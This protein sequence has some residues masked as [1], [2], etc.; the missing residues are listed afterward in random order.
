MAG[1]FKNL[2]AS[3]IRLT[4]FRS[5]KKW[6]S[7]I[8]YDNYYTNVQAN[9]ESIGLLE[10]EVTRV[11]VSDASSSRILK[12]NQSDR[13]EILADEIVT[14]L[15][16]SQYGQD[17]ARSYVAS[18]GTNDLTM[19]DSDLQVAAGGTYSSTVVNHISD[20][21]YAVSSSSTSSYMF[22]AGEGGI[23]GKEFSTL[24]GNFIGSEFTP[25][26]IDDAVTGSFIAVNA[27][28]KLNN[29]KVVALV[30][31][32]SLGVFA[33]SFTGSYTDP[34]NAQ[35]SS[36][37]SPGSAY[38]FGFYGASVYGESIPIT[39][40]T[41][42]Y[43]GTQD[44]YFALFEDG[45]LYKVQ[46]NSTSTLVASGVAE[47]LQD[48]SNFTS[49]SINYQT[50]KIH[51]VYN[52]GQVGIDLI[53]T[54]TGYNEASYEKLID[55]RQ[56]V[57]RKPIVKATIQQN[58]TP[59]TIGIF[60]G[61]TSSLVEQVFFTVNPDTYEIGNPCHFGAT[62]GDLRIEVGNKADN[63]VDVFIGFSSLFSERFIEMSS[64][65]PV[66]QLYKADYNPIPS[67]PSYNPLNTLFDQGSPT[68]DRYEAVTWEGKFQRVVHKSLNHL[69]YESFYNN[70]K[71]VFGNGNINNQ[72][73]FLEDQAY[74]IDLPQ[75]K[76]GEAIQQS[77][78]II[79]ASYNISGS[80]NN[81][82]TIVDDLFGNLYVSGGLVSPVDAT[83]QASGSMSISP[84][85]EWPTKD[86]YKYNGKGAQSFTS[87]FNQGNWQ[88]QTVYENI[89]FTQITGSELPI[90]SPI[91]LLG[92]VPTFDS[93]LSSSIH[94][95]PSEVGEYRQSYNFEN[96]DF[97]IS[98]MI[99]PTEASSHPSGSVVI[100]KQGQAEDYGVDINGNVFSYLANTK[101]PYRIR[102]NSSYELLF[103]RDDLFAT[104]VVSGSL[105]QNQLHHVVAMKSGSNLYMYVDNTLTQTASDLSNASACSNKSD[106]HIGNLDTKERGFDG[107][108]DNVKIY[109]S[110]LG[111]AE[112][113]LLYHTLGRGTT[114]VG[115]AF[116]NHG[117]LVLGSVT[118]RFMDIKSATARGTHTIWEKEISCTVG[119]GEFNRT[120]NP[121]IQQYNPITN[122]YE[123]KSFTTGSDFKPYVTS[124]GLYDEYGQ[125]LVVAKL[126]FP[127]KL[128][129]N[130]DTTFII[131]YDK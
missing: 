77:S 76:Y 116:Y 75:S 128:P 93:S 59:A 119:A 5:H 110:S 122:R 71:A 21:S 31:S 65:Q 26:G 17:Y 36:S 94:I 12:L 11:Y 35:T 46:P 102:M 96:G 29:D 106:I 57:S 24:D 1:I 50:S 123:F 126:G 34:L 100:A 87:S 95:S 20:I 43:C 16:A 4:P 80:N 108:I 78:V 47:I 44:L 9:P 6:N 79:N 27:E 68:F 83:Y 104:A 127:I 117:M 39:L 28:G 113:S 86:L 125:L 19:S 115:N 8:C 22:V 58:Q 74:I 63:D 70:T 67:H 98:F 84:A 37:V 130:V 109:P 112:R 107:L 73:R 51:V 42:L 25:T 53:A 52:T 55:A 124:V 88:M 38:G 41:F 7:T 97:A 111:E 32:G 121:T 54:S 85:G 118:S 30:S 18:Y 60:A 131:R 99:R 82:L 40:K 103:E 23:S 62:K 61:T 10:N 92:V 48:K 2:D 81:S 91:D 3:D 13:Y 33:V 90:P 64:T 15:T 120:N 49:G 56:W 45:F 114:I 69:F 101:S 129:N 72:V 89:T 66:F 14:N 105:T